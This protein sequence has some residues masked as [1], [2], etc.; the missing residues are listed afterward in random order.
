MAQALYKFQ[1]HPFHTRAFL[2]LKASENGDAAPVGEYTVLDREEPLP[3]SES[4][5]R[6][7]IA[8][9]NGQS[10]ENLGDQTGSRLL[11]HPLPGGDAD[12]H[13]RILFQTYDG[14]GV[15]SPNALLTLQKGVLP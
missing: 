6:N 12:P 5:I 13:Q 3:L 1:A 15:S 11:Y 8:L 4:K 7:L 2:I 14:G 10:A 9:L